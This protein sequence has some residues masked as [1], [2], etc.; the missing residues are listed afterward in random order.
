MVRRV[1]YY[2]SYKLLGSDQKPPN[3]QTLKNMNMISDICEQYAGFSQFFANYFE[4]I[5]CAAM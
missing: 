1:N 5:F 3:F 2:Q 4:I